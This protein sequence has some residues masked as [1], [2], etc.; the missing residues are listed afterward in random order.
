MK[1][2]SLTYNNRP[3]LKTGY[4]YYPSENLGPINTWTIPST[5]TDVVSYSSEDTIKLNGKGGHYETCYKAFSV[6][7]TGTYTI[8]YDYNLPTVNFYGTNADHMYFGIFI[9]T[10]QPPGGDM[11]TWSAYSTGNCNGYVICGPSSQNN[12]PGEG[13]AEFNYN[14]TAGTTYY[15]WV[16]MM[17]LA[18]GVLTYLTF[19]NLKWTDTEPV[20]IP[21]YKAR[22]YVYDLNI[23]PQEHGTCVA[24]KYLGFT[25]NLVSV[26]AT[27]DDGWYHIGYN[28]TGSEMTGNDF[29]FLNND[30]NLEPIFSESEGYPITYLS[31]DHVHL[32]GDTIYIPGGTG[33]TLETGYDPYYRISGYEITGGTIENGVLIPTGPCTVKAVQKVNYFTAT[34]NFNYS[35][36]TSKGN[37]DINYSGICKGITGQ[38]PN[39][40]YDNNSAWKPSNPSAYSIS[41]NP[42]IRFY[43]ESYMANFTGRIDLNGA[44]A[45]T[46]TAYLKATGSVPKPSTTVA[47]TTTNKTTT[48]SLKLH[49]ITK[50]TDSF[51]GFAHGWNNISNN[52]WTATGIAP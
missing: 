17:N 48:G 39:T 15:L 50:S 36:N 16:P 24:N 43:L 32:S 46:K 13:H 11:A 22:T 28:I 3:L 21:D 18:D 29:K 23:P 33:I 51:T 49:L 40:W 9:T 6:E 12:S 47:I 1:Q 37:K 5:T 25:D 45:V 30:V 7:K 4:T 10:N 26:T 2:F 20:V 35:N 44:A 8:S 41:T 38:I 19:T 27:P 31:D 42:S 34:G 14:L 52:S